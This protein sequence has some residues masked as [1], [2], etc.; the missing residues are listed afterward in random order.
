MWAWLGVLSACSGMGGGCPRVLTIRR[1]RK[2]SGRVGLARASGL[3]AALDVCIWGVASPEP[4][5]FSPRQS[6]GL[7]RLVPDMKQ[8]YSFLCHEAVTPR[9]PGWGDG[10]RKRQGNGQCDPRVLLPCSTSRPPPRRPG[11]P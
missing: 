1:G 4:R 10:W 9:R 11:I 2:S 6:S 5:S 7:L 8:L 3:L